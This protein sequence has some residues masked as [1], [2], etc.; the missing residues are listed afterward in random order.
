MLT[1]GWGAIVL[2]QLV[3]EGRSVL[4]LPIADDLQTE[5]GDDGRVADD[6][7]FGFVELARVGVDV[8]D[9]V[10]DG[11]YAPVESIVQT[12]LDR[13]QIDG[14]L[15]HVGVRWIQVQIDGRCK[16]FR[17]RQTHHLI[18]QNQNK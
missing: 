18:I 5:I 15:D 16:R 9:V 4:E 1:I 10:L 8:A 2:D 6:G 12:R 11:R 14:V 3:V 17:N 7:R 13:R